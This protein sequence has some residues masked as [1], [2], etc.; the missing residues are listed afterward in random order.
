MT[1]PYME[2]LP[3]VD[4]IT[5]VLI[6]TCVKNILPLPRCVGFYRRLIK[7]F[8]KVTKPLS[9]LLTKEMPFHFSKKCELVFKTLKEALTMA[10]ILHPP[11]WG[12]SFELVR[13]GLEFRLGKF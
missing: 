9:F 4:L 6:A 13:D 12:E 3:K 8:S 2:T 5:N 11:I 1:S 7:D 10:P